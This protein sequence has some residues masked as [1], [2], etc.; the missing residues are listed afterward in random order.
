[1][2]KF[3]PAMVPTPRRERVAWPATAQSLEMVQS[4]AAGLRKRR[5]K[6]GDGVKNSNSDNPNNSPETGR[7]EAGNGPNPSDDQETGDGEAGDS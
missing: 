3:A 7:S 2:S 6:I 1:M 5:R 4:L